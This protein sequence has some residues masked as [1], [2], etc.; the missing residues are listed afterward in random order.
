MS[1]PSAT[2][3]G[4]AEAVLLGAQQ[5]GDDD[6]AAGL[7]AAVG[8][9]RDAVAQAVAHQ[10]LVDLGEAELPGDAHVLDRG[11][12]AGARAADVAGDLDVVGARLGDARGDGADARGPRP[13]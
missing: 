11:E 12:R 6:V 9:Q 13:A 1:Q 7:E 5:R 8:A 10:H 3:R 4:R 2:R